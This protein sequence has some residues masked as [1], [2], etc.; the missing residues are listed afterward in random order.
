MTEISN[1]VLRGFGKGVKKTLK[2]GGRAVIYQR[3]SSREQEDGFSPETQKQ[4]CYE[5][6]KRNQ[7][8]RW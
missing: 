7:Y 4:C 1:E 2:K 5:W 6:A 8:V 3:V